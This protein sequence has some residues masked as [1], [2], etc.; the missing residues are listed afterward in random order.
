VIRTD[1]PLKHRGPDLRFMLSN[2]QNPQKATGRGQSKSSAAG[3]SSRLSLPCQICPESEWRPEMVAVPVG[4]EATHVRL[5]F[6]L[7]AGS[8]LPKNPVMMGF[9]TWKIPCIPADGAA[10]LRSPLGIQTY[11]RFRPPRRRSPTPASGVRVPRQ[12]S[13]GSTQASRGGSDSPV[14]NAVADMWERIDEDLTT[15]YDEVAWR[16]RRRSVPSAAGTTD[17]RPIEFRL[18]RSRM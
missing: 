16:E 11:P 1:D 5:V 3:T 6:L 10:P 8:D 18:P 14:C 13:G 15:A 2:T 17:A 9:L 12:V 7:F 4:I